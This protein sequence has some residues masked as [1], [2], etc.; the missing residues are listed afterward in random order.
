MIETEETRIVWQ[1]K[2]SKFASILNRKMLLKPW[3]RE[4]RAMINGIILFIL[5]DNVSNFQEAIA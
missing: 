2:L 5:Q 1:N 3:Q 4:E